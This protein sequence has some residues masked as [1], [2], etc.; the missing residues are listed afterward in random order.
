MRAVQVVVS[1]RV[2]GVGF[3]FAAIRQA[4]AL[5]VT[6]WVRN[7]SDGRVE[8][9]VEGPDASVQQMLDWLAVGPGYAQVSGLDVVE[10][11]PAGFRDFGVG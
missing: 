3:R 7:R 1:G 2:Q 6:G 10:K 5:G 11:A 9:W 4:A 8:T